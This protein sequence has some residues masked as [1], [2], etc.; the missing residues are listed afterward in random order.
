M[1]MLTV[2]RRP[3]LGRLTAAGLLSEVGDWLLLIALPLF[4][5]D[6]TGSAL[7]TATV[8]ALELLPTVLF[9]PIAGV[10]VDRYE[11]WVL[12]TIVATTQAIFLPA[13]AGGR[14]RRRSLDRLRRGGCRVDP[15]HRHRARA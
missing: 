12:M 1:S 11:R 2:L 7:V 6:L 10:L 9:G 3:R 13:V 15:R 8:F 4:V 14:V 5:L